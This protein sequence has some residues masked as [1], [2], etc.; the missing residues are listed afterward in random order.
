MS[1]EKSFRMTRQ[2]RIILEELRK[3][4]SHPTAREVY[5]F[6]RKRDKR[7]SLGTVYRNLDL[8]CKEGLIQR[9]DGPGAS[10]R[11]D[12]NSKPH[13]HVFCVLCGRTED[14]P[15]EPAIDLVDAVGRITL[16]EIIGQYLSFVG[17]CRECKKKRRPVV[18]P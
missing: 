13:C 11:Y 18:Q 16:Y 14:V 12:G 9:L 10:K 8:L 17:V 3:V 5:E 6:V 1:D 2:R 15:V 7:I 4:T